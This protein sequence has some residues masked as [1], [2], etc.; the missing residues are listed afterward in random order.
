M[1]ASMC[2]E[3]PTAATCAWFC[4]KV[5]E[6]LYSCNKNIVITKKKIKKRREL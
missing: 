2:L 1:M 5:K 3:F 6:V 4:G